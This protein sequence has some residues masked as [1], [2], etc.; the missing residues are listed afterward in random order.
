MKIIEC[1]PNFS[2]G[3]DLSLIKEITDEIESVSG[4]SL[5]DVDSGYDTNRTVVT[6]VGSPE[7]IIYSAF[8]GIK[9]ASELIDMHKHRGTHPRMGAT[10]VCPFVPISNASMDDCVIYSNELAEQ[11]AKKLNIPIFLYEYSAL[12]KDRQNLAVIRKGEFE[13]MTEKIKMTKWKPDYGPVKPHK[14]AG[15]TA[16]GARNFLVAYNINLNTKDKNIATDIALDI[17]EQGRNKRNKKGKFIRDK[18]GIPIKI[19]GTL[20]SCKAVG[21]YLEEYGIAQISMNLTN[22]DDTSPHKAFEE[23]RKQAGKRGIRVTGSELVGLIPLQS[24]INAGKYYLKKQKRSTGTP[25]KDIIHIAIKSMGLDDIFPFKPNEKIIEYRIS[26]KYGELASMKIHEF[27]DELSSDSSAPG[28]GSVSA[29]AGVLSASLSS[30]VSNLTFGKNKWIPLY[31]KMCDI[32][33]KSQALKDQL[34]QLIDKD[35]DSFKLLIAAY[36]LPKKS[37]KDIQTRENA[38]QSAMKEATIIPFQTLKCCRKIMDIA[39][40]A[41]QFGNVNSVSDA[42]VSGEMA[43]AGSNGAALNILINLKQIQDS[44]YC[45]K[46][47]DKTN[48]LVDKTNENLMILRGIIKD[49]LNNE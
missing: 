46:M 24:M 5:L 7:S 45:Q 43:H 27:A 17:R 47:K 39:I 12:A 1:I 37:K 19:P 25:S 10:D 15:V 33:C 36:K 2:E 34:L 41:A 38:I 9:K 16:I 13:G 40:D 26:D 21:W 18:Q 28:G 35:T 30:M 23:I 29:L 32:S 20:K 22:I 8:L 14:T 49:T 11:V 42:G 3:R 6:I 48:L 4:V 44:K 31:D